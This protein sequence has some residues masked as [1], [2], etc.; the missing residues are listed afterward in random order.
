[1]NY[2]EHLLDK[3]NNYTSK[4]QEIDEYRKIQACYSLLQ[5][6]IDDV[7]R[8]NDLEDMSLFNED[9]VEIINEIK[10]ISQTVSASDYNEVFDLEEIHTFLNGLVDKLEILVNRYKELEDGLNTIKNYIETDQVYGMFDDILKIIDNLHGEN[11]IDSKEVINFHFDMLSLVVS[12]GVTSLE[13]EEVIQEIVENEIYDIDGFR[14]IFL[15]YEYDIDLLQDEVKD[16]LIRYG[17]INYLDYVLAKLKEYKVTKK[18]FKERS[19]AIFHIVIDKK[20][21]TFDDICKFIDQN[22]CTMTELLKNSQFFHNGGKRYIPKKRNNRGIPFGDDPISS[23]IFKI[24]GSYDNFIKNIE[25]Y[26]MIRNVTTITDKDLKDKKSFFRA[27][28]VVILSNLKLLVQYGIIVE[29]EFPDVITSLIGVNTQYL[30]D[31]YI[32][33]GDNL[34]NEYLKKNGLSYIRLG[35]NPVKFYKI[36][37]A[38][39]HKENIRW[40]K[41]IKAEF[42]KDEQVYDGISSITENG[43]EEVRQI[44]IFRPSDLDVLDVIERTVPRRT[45]QEKRYVGQIG[46]QFYYVKRKPED[47][48]NVGYHLLFKFFEGTPQK[49]YGIN[50]N[51]ILQI[52]HQ[53]IIARNLLNVMEKYNDVN[54][55]SYEDVLDDEYIKILDETFMKDKFSYVIENENF[56]TLIGDVQDEEGEREKIRVTISRIKVLKLCKMLK[57]EG[58]WI[59]ENTSLSD[60]VNMILSVLLNNSI[61]SNYELILCRFAITKEL[62]NKMKKVVTR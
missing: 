8:I 9:E 4:F 2:K 48:L 7:S 49:I 58:L 30:L 46:G 26:K 16:Y 21:N 50:K 13:E 35:S 44:N 17:D 59:N 52:A 32:E 33:L 45:I 12:L 23:D 61:I 34:Y 10:M 24:T 47:I 56:G 6:C 11:L 41:G 25:L 37:R 15:K 51:N 53:A 29:N 5:A 36:K 3:I 39:L 40:G 20:K 42:N 31:R 43:V 19:I 18:T 14:D 54:Y 22:E 27:S 1:M 28:N 60:K 57:E 55:D 38:L 62:K